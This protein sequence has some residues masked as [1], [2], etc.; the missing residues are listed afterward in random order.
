MLHGVHL[1]RGWDKYMDGLPAASTRIWD[2]RRPTIGTMRQKAPLDENVS[3]NVRFLMER[4]GDNLRTLASRCGVSKST[5][6]RIVAGDQAASI[7]HC[8]AI[9]KAYGLQGWNLLHPDLPR[10]LEDGG[11]LARLINAYFRSSR[12]GRANINRVAELE[13]RYTETEPN[14]E[15]TGTEG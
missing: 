1:S 3:R 15:P 9:A 13:A 5:V 4:H 14:G 2:R 10:D 8:H 12:S 7:E 6:Q 11:T